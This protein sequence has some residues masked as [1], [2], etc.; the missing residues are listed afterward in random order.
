MN[1]YMFFF[2]RFYNKKR[3]YDPIDYACIDETDF[4]IV[5]DDQPI[6][7]DVEELETLLYEEGL[8]PINKVEVQ[9]LILVS[10]ICKLIKVQQLLFFSL[11]MISC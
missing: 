9:V 6:E 5:D 2:F 7:L 4:W 11:K 10:R 3:I 1:N 8:I